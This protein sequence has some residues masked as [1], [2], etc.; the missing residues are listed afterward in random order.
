MQEA[1]EITVKAPARL[2]LGFLDLN[3][4]LGRKFG[5]LGL[6]INRPS[7]KMTLARANGM[8]VKGPDAERARKMLE[9]L[10]AHFGRSPHY[11][12]D[13]ERVIPPHIGFGSGTQLALALGGAFAALENVSLT[14]RDTA[15]LLDRGHRSGIGI[16]VYDAG[17]VILD[18]GRS[19]SG[20]PP[21]VL[22]R[23]PFPPEWRVLLIFDVAMTGNSGSS[24]VSA[25]RT[26]PPPPPEH[27]G[28]LCRLAVM[29][30][31]PA[32]AEKN[33]AAWG[34]AIGQLQRR[35][36][37][38]FAPHQGGQRFNSPLVAKVLAWLE[39]SEVNGI[40]QTS[41]GPT[42]FAFVESSER[43]LQLLDEAK[44]R[45]ADEERL[46]FLICTGR[47]AGAKIQVRQPSRHSPEIV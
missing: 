41:W 14:A 16:G 44:R 43:A 31:L 3:G 4:G 32:L 7:T 35:M 5:S 9:R 21:P 24:E 18:G 1:L 42:G 37:D 2:H 47:N 28:E 27:A 22:S 12:L 6:G 34:A 23:L 15:A 17:G 19:A 36:G 26:L 13:I 46:R 20:E 45:W 29:Q 39:A 25:F 8:S 38:Y 33:I 10:A 30:A 11:C 40:G